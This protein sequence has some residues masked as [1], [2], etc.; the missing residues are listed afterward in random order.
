MWSSDWTL[1]SSHCIRLGQDEHR[2]G[3][4]FLAGRRWKF[5]L[6]DNTN[7]FGRNHSSWSYSHFPHYVNEFLSLTRSFR[8]VS[9]VL[10]FIPSAVACTGGFIFQCHHR[11]WQIGAF[12]PA[13]E[14]FRWATEM[15][16]FRLTSSPHPAGLPGRAWHVW[17]ESLEKAVRN[18][19][20]CV[21]HPLSRLVLWSQW[22]RLFFVS[23][24]CVWDNRGFW[25]KPYLKGCVW[26]K[27]QE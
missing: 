7:W 25:Q 8:H 15:R 22:C 4:I 16:P 27:P 10:Y 21:S 6:P 13:L 12:S 14:P 26:V 9:V 23:S 20:W 18:L 5:C 24:N 3:A 19:L 1:G 11:L 17:T 2:P